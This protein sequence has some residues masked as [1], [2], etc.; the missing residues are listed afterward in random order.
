M[1]DQAIPLDAE[2]KAVEQPEDH[3]EELRLWLRLLTC[4]TLIE[5]EVRRRLRERFDVTLPRF[6]LMAQLDKATDGMMLSDLSRRMMVSNG[7]LTGLVDRLVA[8]GHVVRTVSPTDRRA[9]VISLTEEGRTEFRIMA[10]EHEH[11]IADLF[12]DLTPKDRNDLM[13]L[14]AKTKLSARRAI[15][16]DDQ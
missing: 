16:G 4:S 12:G 11:W 10:G 7:N 8:S 2:T 15:M 14:L 9:V 3:R 1:D 13:R 6:D 5:G